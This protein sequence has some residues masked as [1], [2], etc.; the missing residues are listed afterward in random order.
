MK[1]A[2][3]DSHINFLLDTFFRER[4]SHTAHLKDMEAEL[5]LQMSRIESKAKEKAR[6][7]H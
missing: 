2:F 7:A 1:L 6:S 5:D 3:K 4:E